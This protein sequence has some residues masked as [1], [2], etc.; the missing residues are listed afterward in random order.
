MSPSAESLP[1]WGKG[2]GPFTEVD[3]PGGDDFARYWV[4]ER[5]IREE[6]E[7]PLDVRSVQLGSEGGIHT[8]DRPL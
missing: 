6:G 8:A 5:A 4:F 3:V 1:I 7:G 2:G